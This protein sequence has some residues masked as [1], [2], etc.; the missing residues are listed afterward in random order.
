MDELL[1]QAVVAE[2]IVVEVLI[3]EVRG[4]G[5]TRSA[6]TGESVEMSYAGSIGGRI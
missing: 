2:V 5:L 1:G 4:T 3:E 6:A